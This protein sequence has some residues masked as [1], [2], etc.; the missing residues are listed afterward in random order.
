MKS[1]I[2]AG[3]AALL[4]LLILAAC[5]SAPPASKPALAAAPAVPA[6]KIY[7]GAGKDPSMLNAR[8]YAIMDAVRKGVIELI[9]AANE[10][11]NRDK[12]RSVLY[13]T[14]NPNTFIDK[15]SLQTLRKDKIG[16]DYIFEVRVAVNMRA[17]QSTLRANGLLGDEGLTE[18]DKAAAKAG[19][20]LAAAAEAKVEA[21]TPEEQRFIARYVNNMTYMVYFNDQASEDPFYM[22]AAVGIANEYLASNAMEAVD[23]EQ[24]EKLKKDQQRVYEEQTGQ[25]ISMIQ[26]IAQ[27]LNADVYLEIDGRTTGESSGGKYYGQA[28]VTLKGFE[29]STGR[30]LGSQPWNSPRTFSTASQQAARVN[31]LQTSVYKAMPIVL[32]QAK[33]YM[34]KAMASG[35]K[36][37]LVVQGSS[38]GKAMSDFRR[39]L[40]RKVKEVLTVSQAAEETRYAV[41]LIG[42][43]E[44]LAEAVLDV[45]ETIPG[46]EGMHQVVLRGKSVTFDTGN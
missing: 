30:L 3:A 32:Q 1:R 33:T 46:L 36:Y 21:A 37:E 27:R 31:A 11:A 19:E 24:V 28:S 14:A 40:K 5:A 10:Q 42:S 18:E 17:V 20:S 45:A 12:L 43:V 35:I 25:S 22:K 6:S 34:A 41:F 9:G 15:V 44:D 7:E 2:L 39:K 16:Q 13:S 4:S 26:W 8:T 29:A 23:M 38:E